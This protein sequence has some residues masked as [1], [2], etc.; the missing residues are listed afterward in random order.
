MLD[1]LIAYKLYVYGN[2]TPITVDS[3]DSNTNVTTLT[4]NSWSLTVEAASQN[5][6]NFS[7][8]PYVPAGINNG[9][10]SAVYNGYSYQAN[11]VP[12]ERFRGSLI[13][14]PTSV[15]W[16]GSV[17][18]PQEYS[19]LKS[20]FFWLVPDQGYV[21]SRHNVSVSQ[22]DGTGTTTYFDYGFIS[23]QYTGT[24]NAVGIGNYQNT[25][26]DVF[27]T[28]ATQGY[29]MDW[30]NTFPNNIAQAIEYDQLTGHPYE[31]PDGGTAL[32]SSYRGATKYHNVNA[33]ISSNY[34]NL[35]EQSQ[36][37]NTIFVPTDS[38][39]PD[40]TLIDSKQYTLG[41]PILGQFINSVQNTTP[42]QLDFLSDDS[43]A[44]FINNIMPTQYC[45]S[46]WINN[47]VLVNF[48]YLH[49]Y[50]PGTNPN[51]IKIT[52]NGAAT[53]YDNQQCIPFNVNINGG[54]DIG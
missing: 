29:V 49:Y 38:S 44:E 48:T 36:S 37:L 31:T 51:N 5:Q 41:T 26:T 4:N 14:N 21:L 34:N 15:W 32:T 3:V 39:N 2:A 54:V 53:Q 23:G 10:S 27:G 25:T 11:W 47:S 9:G 6:A 20:I 43:G 45:T 46:D 30:V 16:E 17:A 40:I 24:S 1:G 52:I 18:L 19:S 33:T 28:A 50:I 22:V 12:Q 7:V 35:S 13:F 42:A 8:I